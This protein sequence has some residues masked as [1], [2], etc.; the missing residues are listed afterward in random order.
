MPAG[1][2]ITFLDHFNGQTNSNGQT[3]FTISPANGDYAAGVGTAV[4][5]ST[6]P[7]TDTGYFG[8]GDSAFYIAN[9][10]SGVKEYVDIDGH[11]NIQ[12][13][14]HTSGGITVGAWFKINAV[15]SGLYLYSNIV[16]LGNVDG[17]DDYLT[18]AY[19]PANATIPRVTF[20]DS[21]H[22][23]TSISVSPTAASDWIYLAAT[24]DLDSKQMNFYVYDKDGNPLHSGTSSF[25]TTDWNP[26]VYGQVRIGGG[27]SPTNNVWID[28]VSV[29]D[30]VLTESQITARVASMAAGNPLSVPEPAAMALL[31][32]GGLMLIRRK[33]KA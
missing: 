32:L 17:K 26:E 8:T 28:E 21:G 4:V 27:A 11:G 12:Y 25:A 24:V 20:L 13:T 5:S 15:T 16:T 33:R 6:A 29:D 18:L 19:A 31:G 14:S 10:P 2:A 22:D 9:N 3:D 30:Q 7:T 1:A 23:S